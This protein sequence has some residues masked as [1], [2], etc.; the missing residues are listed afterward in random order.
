MSRN[1]RLRGHCRPDNNRRITCSP[2]Y[3]SKTAGYAVHDDRAI[4][5]KQV[6]HHAGEPL[7]AVTS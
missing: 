4:R 7:R 3:P 1:L 6:L 2:H 5:L